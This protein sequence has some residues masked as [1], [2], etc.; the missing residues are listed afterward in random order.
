MKLD[1]FPGARGAGDHV[2]WYDNEDGEGGTVGQ[3]LKCSIAVL[4][5]R[6]GKAKAKRD[7]DEYEYLMVEIAAQEWCS[8]L[9]AG[10]TKCLYGYEFETAALARKFLVAM[11]AAAKAAKH[12]FS[13]DV[14]YPEWARTALAAGWKP[15]K[16]W[17]P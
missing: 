17:K 11:R 13:S 15:P 2:S 8:A 5:E 9:D 14:E 1:I 12:S 10:V 6:A 16:G 7:G 3:E 4:G